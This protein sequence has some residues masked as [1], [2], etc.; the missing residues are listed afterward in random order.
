MSFGRITEAPCLNVAPPPDSRCSDPAFALNNP[1]TCPQAPLL[2]VKPGVSLLCELGSVQF[3]ASMFQGGVETDVTA[4][5]VWRSSDPN[6]AVI[7]ALSGNATGLAAGTATISASYQGMT[8]YAEITTLTGELCCEEISTAFM[9]VVDVTKS[10]GQAFNADYGSKLAYAKAAAKDFIESVNSTK[11]TV[12]LVSF[13]KEVATTH[14]APSAD[15][16]A[17]SALVD[18]LVQTQ[19]LTS[20]YDAMEAAV[21]A[22]AGVSAD[23]KMIVLLS[24]GEDTDTSYTS[25]DNPIALLN[26]FKQS[27]GIVLCVGVRA[28]GPAYNLLMAFS[29]GGFF[30]NAHDDTADA[31]LAYLTGLRSYVCGGNCADTG[32]EYVPAGK[33]NYGGFA[34]WRLTEG[35]VD[36][37]G[38][39]VM[40][41]LPGN[42]LYLDMAGS[43]A[44]YSGKIVTE[45]S[46]AVTLGKQYALALKIA[47][48]QRINATPNALRVQVFERNNDGLDTPAAPVPVTAEGA[49]PLDSPETYSYLYSYVNANGETD[50][51]AAASATVSTE[52]AQVNVTLAANVNATLIRIY[53]TTGASPE[54]RYYLIAEA[55]PDSTTY[56]DTTRKTAMLASIASGA[57]DDSIYPAE[58][59]ATGTPIYHLNQQ[60]AISDFKQDFKE[61]Y[62]SFTAPSTGDVFL[63]VQQTATPAGYDSIGLLVDQ[64]RL[65]NLTDGSTE[66]SDDF[67]DENP[68]YVA[69]DCGTGT[70]YHLLDDGT[71]GYG[72]GYFCYGE[73]CLDSPPPVQTQDPNPLSDIEAGYT[74]PKTYTSTQEACAECPE[75][76]E[77]DGLEQGEE[78]ATASATSE[79][80]QVHADKL[81]TDAALAL[82]QSR[83]NCVAY[84]TETAQYIAHCE[85]GL[86]SD[87]TRSATYTSYISQ[88]DAQEQAAALAK[89]AAEAALVCAGSNNLQLNTILD[90]A[91][92]AVGPAKAQLYPQ[93]KYI[94]CPEDAI[95]ISN[96]QLEI[97][98]AHGD[99]RDV[100]MILESPNGTC[101]YLFGNS[102]G[103][104]IG[105]SVERSFVL[106]SEGTVDIPEHSR[107]VSVVDVGPFYLPKVY[108]VQIDPFPSPGPSGPFSTSLADLIGETARGSWKLWVVDDTPLYSGWT[109]FYL[110]VFTDLGSFP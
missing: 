5:C 46:I 31:T 44:E 85:S 70:L 82:A 17:V 41:L 51:S 102:Q 22:L 35:H 104:D 97:S 83:L 74:P 77:P 12:G 32:D 75:G 48:N 33:L 71:Y 28:W 88:Q 63:S 6:V 52:D 91:S 105:S 30:I 14:S 78:C 25:D 84:W 94:D 110:S 26:D 66:F 108:G 3:S 76:M 72:Y 89:T 43:R 90:R 68:T 7:G 56:A 64:V 99:P 61:Y 11:D 49:V 9:V 81:A 86:G 106:H 16:A 80:S 20:F 45:A 107:A 101:V 29:T 36:L 100:H 10:M 19:Q 1:D 38:G 103:A 18:G 37:V 57:V 65:L 92:G 62:L 13:T 4:S 95:I 98:M 93:V 69:P 21:T 79:I 109:W 15:T 58:T 50:A 67:D 40:D 27:G 2:L 8:A 53:R 47:G 54:S 55:A 34:N 39:G 73:G 23:R 96:V 24:D 42:G 60:I 59:N 87:V